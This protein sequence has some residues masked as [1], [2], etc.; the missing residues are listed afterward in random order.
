MPGVIM[1]HR[2]RLF[3]SPASVAAALAVV[4]GSAGGQSLRLIDEAEVPGFARVNGMPLTGI[5]GLDFDPQSNRWIAVSNDTGRSGPVRF[6][7]IKM[8]F[9]TTG[10][11]SFSPDQAQALN[12][13][14]G[15]R[16]E[17]GLHQPG[18][19]RI[20]PADPIGDEP[21]LVWTS[22]G[23]LSEGRRGGVFEMC[24]GATFMDW[25]KVGD[26]FE[27]E[28]GSMGPSP[29]RAWSS[30]ALLPDHSLVAA[31]EQPLA[32]DAASGFVRLVA[33]DYWSAS[34]QAEYA[35]A[36]APV[37]ETAPAGAER[38]LV[39]LIAVDQDTLLSVES[40]MV[41]GQRR[42]PKAWTEVYLVELAG[43][44]DVTGEASLASGAG[45]TPVSKRLL[46]DTA[47]LGLRDVR[48]NA[49]A[50]WYT[51]EDGSQGLVLASDNGNDQYR[52]T[53]FAALALEGLL[54]QR[55]FV[56]DSAGRHA[57][58]PGPEA[59]QPKVIEWASR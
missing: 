28:P 3:W 54:A 22:E 49:G 5:S 33:L 2:D 52:P 46:G 6:F 34:A 14:D 4:A 50:F 7:G 26:K 23:V 35:Y 13:P 51:L 57:P 19:V 27:H 53:Y 12:H 18:A 59:S 42:S 17:A 20:I 39:E 37:P 9:D 15:T 11:G 30:L 44:T 32:Q 8:A 45:V 36:L 21:Y 38:S 29:D 58:L 25:F 10:M 48:Y 55:P 24:T 47:S 16:F 40:V 41:P 43:A 31:C 56:K 1:H